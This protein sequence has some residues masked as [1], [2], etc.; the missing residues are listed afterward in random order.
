MKHSRDHGGYPTPDGSG[1]HKVPPQDLR[2]DAFIRHKMFNDRTS[3]ARKY[4]DLTIGEFSVLKLVKYELITSLLGPLPGAMGLFLRKIFYPLLLKKVGRGVMFGRN[5]VLRHCDKITIGDRVVIDDNTLLDARGGDEGIVIGDDVIINRA[6]QIQSKVG[7]VHIG[8]RSDIGTGTAIVSQGGVYVDE[9]V[10][11][12][13]ACKI[14]GGL[15]HILPNRDGNPPYRRYS[16]GPVRIGKR[17]VLAMGAMILDGV[18]VGEGSMVGSGA[19][20]VAN[21]PPY[22]IIS[23]RPPMVMQNPILSEEGVAESETKTGWEGRPSG[24]N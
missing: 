7:S 24:E 15:F 5:V 16:K 20:V 1:M 19:V 10:C 21:I 23:P 22:S 13:A 11:I 17:C 6:C 9:Q 18:T 3:A 2:E 4:A 14:S 8:A 12:A